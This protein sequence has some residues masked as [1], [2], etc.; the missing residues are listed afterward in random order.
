MATSKR[1]RAWVRYDGQNRIVPSSLILQVSRPKIGTWEEI[2]TSLTGTT[3]TAYCISCTSWRYDGPDVSGTIANAAL[4]GG[5][6]CGD[7]DVIVGQI[8]C[9]QFG[10]FTY[11]GTW[12]NMG[13]C[14]P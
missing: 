6:I 7:I 5:N 11:G 14:I 12:T 1:L 9:I 2:P 13:V 3:T 4:C 8:V 10:Q